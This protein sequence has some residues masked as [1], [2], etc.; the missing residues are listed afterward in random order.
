M[1]SEGIWPATAL[2]ATYGEDNGVLV[3]RIQVRFDEGPN[4]GKV[5][6][7]EDKLDAR[8]SIYIARSCQAVGWKPPKLE[9]LS[10]DVDAWIKATGGK[11]TAMVKHIEIRKGKKFDKYLDAHNAWIANGSNGPEPQPPIWDKVSSIGSGPKPLAAPK[12]ETLA[13]A[14]DFMRKALEDDGRAPP[15]DDTPHAADADNDIPF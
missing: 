4:A 14:D 7:Y 12:A 8:S 1:L 9:T 5:G 3:V 11:T 10:S 2:G 13:D 15:P 6:T